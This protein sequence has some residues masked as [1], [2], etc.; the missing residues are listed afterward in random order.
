[1]NV[2]AVR[3][4]LIIEE[5]PSEEVVASAKII[6]SQVDK[7]AVIIRPIARFRPAAAPRGKIARISHG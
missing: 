7:M 4:E 1:M 2:V 5:A 6:K 3:S